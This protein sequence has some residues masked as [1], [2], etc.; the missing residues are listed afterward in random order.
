[1]LALGVIFYYNKLVYKRESFS[2]TMPDLT[3][4]PLL[5]KDAAEIYSFGG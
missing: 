1:V 3:G 2:C 5:Y 4:I